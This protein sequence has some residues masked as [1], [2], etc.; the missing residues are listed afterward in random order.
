MKTTIYKTTAA[1]I[2]VALFSFSNQKKQTSLYIIGDST[3]ANKEAKAYPETGWG[4]ELQ[5]FFNSDVKVDNR[6]L[7]GRST[8]SFRAEGRWQPIF[9]NL[10]KGDYVFIEFGHNDEKVDKPA[11][12]VSLANFKVNL[13]NYV[14]ETRSKKAIPVLLTP[15]SRRT[16]KDGV[17]IDSHGDYPKITRQVADSLKVPLIDMLVKTESLLTRLGDAGSIK[18]FNHVDSGHVNYPQGKKDDTHLS[19]AGAKQ[20]AG[21]VVQGIQELKLGLAKRLARD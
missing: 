15:I 19:P 14:N 10:K 5:A 20:V 7:N 13:I 21:L 2:L 6:A 8:K 11:V 16:F 9:D 3:A 4:M 17:L 1:I 18:L 12:G